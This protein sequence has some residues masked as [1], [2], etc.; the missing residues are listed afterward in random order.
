MRPFAPNGKR[1]A[2]FLEARAKILCTVNWVNYYR[3]RCSL[4]RPTVHVAFFANEVKNAELV[5]EI[6]TYPLLNPDIGICNGATVAL[7]FN[8]F[9]K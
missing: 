3:P 4:I 2:P 1:D 9:S 6:L 5:G 8:I 7:P